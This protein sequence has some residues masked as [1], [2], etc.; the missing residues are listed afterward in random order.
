MGEYD[1]VYFNDIT[2]PVHIRNIYLRFS[3]CTIN[4]SDI[5]MY[6][7]YIRECS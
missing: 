4:N 5:C 7:L 3:M 2:Q 6:I 1:G